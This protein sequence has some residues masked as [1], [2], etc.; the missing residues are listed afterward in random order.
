MAAGPLTTGLYQAARD[1]ADNDLVASPGDVDQWSMEG[2]RYPA[3]ARTANG[4]ALVLDA[5]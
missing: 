2:T 1:R 5:M 3:F 4:G